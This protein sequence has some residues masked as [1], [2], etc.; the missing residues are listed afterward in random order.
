MI[1]N[2]P[3][4]VLLEL[5]SVARGLVVLDQMVKKAPV[6]VVE[7]GPIMPGKYLI[8]VE[9]GVDEVDEALRAGRAAA[10]DA[11]VD[12]TFLPFP[13]EALRPL[14]IAPQTPTLSALGIIEGFS[15][16]GIVRAADAALKA[17]E[18]VPV[19]LDRG[20]H[21][22]GKAALTLTGELHDIDAAMIAAREALGDGLLAGLEII[23]N[24]HPDVRA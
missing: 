2:G 20:Q 3:A 23:A 16:A 14:L 11:L 18:V 12:Q 13:H 7:A 10:G 4:L 17:A 15:I 22:G 19:R 6:H 24:P 21:L 9:G 5:C 1:P 8:R